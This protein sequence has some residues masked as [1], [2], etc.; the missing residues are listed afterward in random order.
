MW[1]LNEGIEVMV[2]EVTEFLENAAEI[3]ERCGEGIGGLGE[4]EI[5][6]RTRSLR[7]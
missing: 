5:T 6:W 1:E 2:K 4:V 3:F 7:R